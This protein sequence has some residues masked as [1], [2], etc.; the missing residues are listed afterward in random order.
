MRCLK[1][2]VSAEIF[3]F[4][5]SN[6]VLGSNIGSANTDGTTGS[7]SLLS[8]SFPGTSYVTLGNTGLADDYAFE[9]LAFTPQVAAIPE[10]R[11][12]PLLLTF[13]A[14]LGALKLKPDWPPWDDRL[15]QYRPWVLH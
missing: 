8:V 9:D 4:D 10:P 2:A 3:R 6:N 15:E 14:A 1:R 7:N 11:S 13:M 5:S 12:W